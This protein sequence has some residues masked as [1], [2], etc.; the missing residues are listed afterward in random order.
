MRRYEHMFQEFKKGVL[1]KALLRQA[2]IID[3][4]FAETGQH[5]CIDNLYCI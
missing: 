5:Y 2:N 3:N 1:T 4:S